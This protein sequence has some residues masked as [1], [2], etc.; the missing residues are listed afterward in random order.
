MRFPKRNK[1]D[2]K[3]NINLDY[4]R[5]Y[6]NF[7]AYRFKPDGIW[8]SCYGSWYDWIVD[9]DMV[10]GN[11]WLKKYIHKINIKPGVLTDVRS[12]SPSDSDKLLVIKNLKDLK[13]FNNKYGKYVELWKGEDKV[14]LINWELYCYPDFRKFK[15]ISVKS[16]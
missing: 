13:I 1:L 4:T 2:N 5:S 9:Q 11:Q 8:Y 7:D 3:K 16:P 10:K 15:E 12:Q 6:Q 14:F